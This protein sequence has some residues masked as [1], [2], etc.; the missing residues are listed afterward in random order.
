MTSRHLTLLRQNMPPLTFSHV[1][2]QAT[3][4]RARRAALNK[5]QKQEA[6]EEK[7]SSDMIAEEAARQREAAG[8]NAVNSEG[9][10]CLLRTP[11]SQTVYAGRTKL[12]CREAAV[13]LS[14]CRL[15]NKVD[16][17]WRDGGQ[18][19]LHWAPGTEQCVHALSLQCSLLS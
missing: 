19:C 11:N 12:E 5:A 1:C 16:E 18:T 2:V 9:G 15:Q 6:D 14:C 17:T 10:A 3:L 7:P 13:P 8:R 4:A